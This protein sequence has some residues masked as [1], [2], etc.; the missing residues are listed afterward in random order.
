MTLEERHRYQGT[1]AGALIIVVVGVFLGEKW[2]VALAGVPLGFV[3]FGALSGVPDP[4][5]SLDREIEPRRPIPADLVTV[6]LTV[7]NEGETSVP[8]LRLVD[9]VPDALSVVD[10]RPSLS[11]ALVPGQSETITYTLRAKRGIHSFDPPQVRVRGSAADSYRDVTTPVDG[12]MEFAARI[13]LDN[14]PT[15]RETATLVGAVT[16]DR[17]GSG[18]EFHTVRKYRPGDPI[19]RIE[20]RRFARDGELATVNY[21]EYGG[22]SVLVV[23]DCRPAADIVPKPGHAA[24]SDLCQYA[25]DRI[26]HASTDDGHET[27]LGVLGSTSIPWVSLEASKVH[28][29]ARS[30]LRAVADGDSWDGP[31]IHLEQIT[32][33]STL[34]ERI[35]D[36]LHPG[37]QVVL[38]TPLGDD[39]PV[40]FVR[41]LTTHGYRVSVLS[42][43]IGD[44]ETPGA[45]LVR[46]ERNTRLQQLREEGVETIDWP[47]TDPLPVALTSATG[48]EHS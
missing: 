28:I 44:S 12:D 45:R 4:D 5:I 11:T 27:G 10:G 6:R 2:A 25:A 46:A 48:G 14:P 47:R 18:V 31:E 38:I 9:G 24:G 13:F 16:S 32:D 39:V 19:N 33:G 37:T 21:R 30:A 34:A 42:P 41:R 29:Q 43:D 7:H 20:W 22:L 1:I 23:A 40:T 3:V 35:I 26:V 8:D 15:V 17:G 36:R